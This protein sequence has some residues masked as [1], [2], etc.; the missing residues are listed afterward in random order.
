MREV[1]KALDVG[2]H[3]ENDSNEMFHRLPFA[4]GSR[5]WS[6]DLAKG[7]KPRLVRR[8]GT[9]TTQK[10][11]IQKMNWVRNLFQQYTEQV[12]AVEVLLSRAR[13][14]EKLETVEDASSLLDDVLGRIQLQSIENWYCK[15]KID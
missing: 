9:M 11:I 10:K 8:S 7:S 12:V 2:R 1:A 3:G 15:M 14:N 5:G 4:T 6:F 13:F